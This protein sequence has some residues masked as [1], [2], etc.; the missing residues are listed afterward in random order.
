MRKYQIHCRLAEND[1]WHE[2]IEADHFTINNP[3]TYYHFCNSQTKK[4][5]L[6]PI[7]NTIIITK[8]E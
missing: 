4:E 7:N 5:W 1:C 6:F 2:T 3:G 8:P